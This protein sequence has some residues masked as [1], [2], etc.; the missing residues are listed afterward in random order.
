ML[1]RPLI[2][3]EGLEAE[4]PDRSLSPSAQSLFIQRGLHRSVQVAVGGLAIRE[5][6]RSTK[7]QLHLSAG[8]GV[9]RLQPL[10]EQP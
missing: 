3:G 1:S 9:Q 2:A 4:G 10:P 8:A 6:A 5:V 7:V